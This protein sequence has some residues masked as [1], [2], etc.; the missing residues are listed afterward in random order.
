VRLRALILAQRQRQE[1]SPPEL[2]PP[3]GVL[4]C[5][6]RTAETLPRTTSQ[7]HGQALYPIAGRDGV[8]LQN[9]NRCRAQLRPV[10]EQPEFPEL[11]LGGLIPEI[12]RPNGARHTA[13]ERRRRCLLSPPTPPLWWREARRYGWT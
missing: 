5:E 11:F 13:L 8:A 2:H 6:Y 10:P 3:S 12:C 9:C 4:A 7:R 1:L